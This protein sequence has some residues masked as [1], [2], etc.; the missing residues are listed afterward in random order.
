[1]D[2]RRDAYEQTGTD[3]ASG[4]RITYVQ[5]NGLRDNKTNFQLDGVTRTMEAERAAQPFRIGLDRAI[6][7]AIGECW[8]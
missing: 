7:R 8:S 2:S 5:G 3:N 4:M 1:L 6:Q